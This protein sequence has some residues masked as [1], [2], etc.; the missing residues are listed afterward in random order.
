MHGNVEEWVH[1]WYAD[2]LATPQ[3]NP[4]GP[5]SDDRRVLR[6]GS[7]GSVA[8]HARSAFRWRDT[9]SNR[10][11]TGATFGFR[12][13]RTAVSSD[14]MHPKSITGF[15]M[16]NLI[17]ITIS[18][19]PSPDK[20]TVVV[21]PGVPIGR[22]EVLARG[23]DE[24][25]QSIRLT[26]SP[27]NGIIRRVV[28]NTVTIRTVK[29]S[30]PTSLTPYETQ[31]LL[32]NQAFEDRIEKEDPQTGPTAHNA[33][34]AVRRAELRERLREDT[35]TFKLSV[36]MGLIS[37]SMYF[38]GNEIGVG[39]FIRTLPTL[40]GVLVE[41]IFVAGM[42]APLLWMVIVPSFKHVKIE[43]A[44]EALKDL[45]VKPQV[46]PDGYIECIT[47][48]EVDLRQEFEMRV[49]TDPAVQTALNLYE[50]RMSGWLFDH[51]RF[52]HDHLMSLV[53]AHGSV[54]AS[55]KQKLTAAYETL[56]HLKRDYPDCC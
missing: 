31:A 30:L 27:V 34:N 23:V 21:E 10:G 32:A 55:M 41:M 19:P 26:V 45:P 35:A 24:A 3:T 47:M 50:L 48:S 39:Q 2:L 40:L 25:S 1:D 46:L 36:L 44:M 15:S 51:V 38:W 49:R 11:G 13:A 52:R 33:R 14:A 8:P 17:D 53:H 20:H 42:C 54:P 43:S 56:A 4:T 28:Q 9:P 22:G 5:M 12:L 37:W 29:T 6:G 16:S 18:V 7:W